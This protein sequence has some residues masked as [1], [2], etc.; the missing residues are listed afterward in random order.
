MTNKKQ[1]LIP[2]SDQ[3][4]RIHPECKKYTLRDNGFTET[5]NGKFQLVR[6]LSFGSDN[7]TE[8]QLKVVISSTL[9]SLKIYVTNSAL[10]SVNVFK[11]ENLTVEKE[12]LKRILNEMLEANV[13][14]KIS[15]L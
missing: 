2:G 10:Q 15:A 1:A 9:D 4:Y 5:K 12:N 7:K 13:L 6:S 11:K 3:E 14:E 8:I